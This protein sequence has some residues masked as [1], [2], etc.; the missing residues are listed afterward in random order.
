[1]AA[2]TM[3]YEFAEGTVAYD[4]LS[5]ATPAAPPNTTF[6]TYE[7]VFASGTRA[8]SAQRQKPLCLPRAVRVACSWRLAVAV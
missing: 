5:A 7:R 1:M 4:T 2:A 6:V 3:T 8:E